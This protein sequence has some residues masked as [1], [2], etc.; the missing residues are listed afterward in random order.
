MCENLYL[1]LLDYFDNASKD[2]DEKATRKACK[3]AITVLLPATENRIR[4]CEVDYQAKY[5]QLWEK[6]LAFAGRRSLEHFIDYMELEKQVKVL[7]SRRNILKPFLFYLNKIA[8]DDKL[9]YIICSYYPSA[10]KSFSL[11]YFTAWLYGLD[12]NNSVIRMS[13][14]DDLVNGFSRAIK[15]IIT[16]PRF[17]DVFPYFKSYAGNPFSTKVV[18]NW[19][20]K[21]SNVVYSHMA[22]S[23]DGQI[24]GK[25]ANKAIIFDDMTKG[26]DE[27]T[28]SALHSGIYNKWKTDWWNRRDGDRT[29]YI[30]AGTMWSPEDILNRVTQDREA[31][32]KV[33]ESPLYKYVWQTEDES[34]VFI[35]IPLLDEND[36]STCEAVITTSE[37]KNLRD[38]T[39]EFSFACVYQQSPIPPTGLN[40]ADELLNH[41][42]VLPVNEDGTSALSNYS[43]A[44]LD[45]TRRG[46]DNMSMPIFRTDGEKYYMVDCL[47]KQKAMSDMYDEILSKIEEHNITWLVVENNTD[48]SLKPLLEQKLKDKGIHT[49]I[50]TEKYN[51]VKKEM[52]ILQSQGLIRK[53]LVFKEKKAYT[54]TSDYGKLMTNLH[55]YS[56]DYPN[57]HDDAP[58]SLSLFVTEIILEKG[59]PAKPQAINRYELGF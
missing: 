6:T 11:N 32:S 45:T 52:R 37:A 42:D 13:Y 17:S 54:R 26:N 47:F 18:D 59:K 20:L 56:F 3:Y 15:D 31:L 1:I 50:I 41:Y 28:N 22:V 40:F 16:E 55:T 21:N 19:K 58:D 53:L 9:K 48:T 10:G 25:R 7:A 12:I 33:V 57:K 43:L 23:R 39:D 35:R 5:Y 27:A 38:T 51:T 14:S 36:V 4:K 44:V 8:F 46:K 2:G 34:T 29:K 30:F 49:C 24:T